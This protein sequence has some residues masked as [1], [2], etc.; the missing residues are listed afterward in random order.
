MGFKTFQND[1]LFNIFYINLDIILYEK[2]QD[3]LGFVWAFLWE[4]S[5]E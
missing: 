4:Y 5:K 3:L 1:I 2:I